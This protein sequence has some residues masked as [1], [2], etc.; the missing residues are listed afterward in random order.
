M[1]LIEKLNPVYL[2]NNSELWYNVTETINGFQFDIYGVNITGISDGD[3]HNYGFTIQYE[4]GSTFSRV[5]A[6]STSAN[7]V[8]PGCGTLLN[9][10]YEGT[11][12][13]ISNIIFATTFG[14]PMNIDYA[15]CP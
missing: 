9:I 8:P 4:N 7:Y 1:S 10:S 12:T 11:I 2:T 5:L 15:V 13:D 6:F 3:A 14:E